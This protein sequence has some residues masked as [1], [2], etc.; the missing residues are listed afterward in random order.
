MSAI[1]VLLGLTRADLKYLLDMHLLS[2]TQSAIKLAC[3]GNPEFA[4]QSH[5]VKNFM[6]IV[7]FGLKFGSKNG[8]VV[9]LKR[10]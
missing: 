9:K 7:K 4:R 2:P 1:A 10:G 8:A 6:V 5:D 3:N